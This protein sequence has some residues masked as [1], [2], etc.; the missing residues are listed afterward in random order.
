MAVRV[1]DLR[2][3]GVRVRRRR[4]RMTRRRKPRGVAGG[5]RRDER[6]RRPA[7]QRRP[8]R[9]VRSRRRRGRRRRGRDA[10]GVEDASAARASG[11]AEERR[12]LA[13]E[14]PRRRRDAECAPATSPSM[15]PVISFLD[16]FASTPRENCSRSASLLAHSSRRASAAT[17]RT[18]PRIRRPAARVAVLRRGGRRRRVER[19]SRRDLAPPE[20]KS[21]QITS[22]APARPPAGMTPPPPPSPPPAPSWH[23]LPDGILVSVFERIHG[24]PRGRETL[25]R[26]LRVCRG[27]RD[28]ARRVLLRDDGDSG[29]RAADGSRAFKLAPSS[30][31]L[32]GPRGGGVDGSSVDGG[33]ARAIRGDAIDEESVEEDTEA[34]SKRRRVSAD[35]GGGGGGATRD[36]ETT[37]AEMDDAVAVDGDVDGSV[38]GRRGRDGRRERRRDDGRRRRRRRRRFFSRRPSAPSAAGSAGASER[39]RG[40]ADIANERDRRSTPTGDDVCDSNTRAIVRRRSGLPVGTPRAPLVEEPPRLGLRRVPVYTGPH[41]TARAR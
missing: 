35:G 40:S 18:R 21:Q 9:R 32:E 27:W 25:L 28:D 31:A 10:E 14:L 12:H 1:Q 38:Q 23:D 13:R 15:H 34:C 3:R 22:R 36:A 30:T 20:I 8:R 4:G 16:F 29:R 17:T 11:G 6:G 2:V 39:A 26:C 5:R 19:P 37:M 41:T 33:S 7:R 24:E